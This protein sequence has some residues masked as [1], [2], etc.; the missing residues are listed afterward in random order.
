MTRLP[1]FTAALALV[2][3]PLTGCNTLDR[4]LEPQPQGNAADAGAV[5]PQEFLFTRY[6]PLNRWLDQAVRVQINDVPLMDVFNHPALRGFQYAVVKAPPENP[7]ISMDKIALTRRQL[8]WALSHDHQLF[9][10]PVFDRR[11]AV[12]HIEIRSRSVDLPN[13]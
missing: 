10:S 4:I 3:L 8:L 12:T 1:L 7:L 9:M 5:L 13:G 2:T 6:A 11:G